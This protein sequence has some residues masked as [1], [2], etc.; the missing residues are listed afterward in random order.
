MR[1]I[2]AASIPTTPPACCS[3]IELLATLLTDSGT[4]CCA[5][6]HSPIGRSKWKQRQS[7]DL[8]LIRRS[9]A[10]NHEA[11]IVSRLV[12][13]DYWQR[14]C[15]LFFPTV[16]GYTYGSAISPDN[17]VHKVNSTLHSALIFRDPWGVTL[18]EFSPG[19]RLFTS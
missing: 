7:E 10:P 16:N 19:S 8:K 18:P 9:G 3:L 2:S 14:Q 11:T 5:M 6:N 12:N 15:A 13:A 4:G 1:M 17:N